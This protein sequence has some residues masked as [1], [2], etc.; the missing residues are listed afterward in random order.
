[1]NVI[2]GMVTA[3]ILL[4]GC[5]GSSPV[6]ESRQQGLTLQIKELPQDPGGA[7]TIS[8]AARL[9]PDKGMFSDNAV[10]TKLQ[11]QMDSTFY[12]QSGRDRIYADLVQPVANGVTGTY[13]Y[14]VSFDRTCQGRLTGRLIYQDRYLNHQKYTIN[15]N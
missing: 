1:M 14:L 5:Q 9:I 11:Y 6:R 3:L 8:Y 10:K 4:T 12:I 13:E 2:L 15:L 7:G